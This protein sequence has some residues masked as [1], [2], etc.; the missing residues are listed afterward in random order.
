[1]HVCFPEA[2]N[3]LGALLLLG[4]PGVYTHTTRT[5]TFPPSYVDQTGPWGDLMSAQDSSGKNGASNH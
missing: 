1:M 3:Y 4:I 5:A 2:E